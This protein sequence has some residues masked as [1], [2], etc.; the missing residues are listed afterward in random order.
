MIYSMFLSNIYIY[1]Y[2][3]MHLYIYIHT[4]RICCFQKVQ[5]KTFS[6]AGLCQGD[7]LA[8]TG[9]RV[10]R[11]WGYLEVQRWLTMFNNGD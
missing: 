3:Q 8:E 7:Q 9:G 1:I 4:Q 11:I 10:E 6:Q 2:M 5:V